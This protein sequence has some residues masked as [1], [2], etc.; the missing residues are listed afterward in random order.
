MQPPRLRV[1]LLVGAVAHRDRQRRAAPDLV[2]RPRRG[3]AEVEAGAPGGGDGARMDPL[4][5]VGAG[6]RPPGRPWSRSTDRQR[7]GTAPSSQCTRT[8]PAPR[9]PVL[10]VR[11][12]RDRS[13]SRWTYRRRPSPLDRLRSI[14]PAASSTSRWWA[15]RFEGTPTSPGAPAATGQ[16]PS[17]GRRSPSG[18]THRAQ[19]GP[20]PAAPTL[21][22]RPRA[23]HVTH[24][25]LRQHLLSELRTTTRSGR[26]AGAQDRRPRVRSQMAR[27]T[28]Q[29]S[30][31]AA[32]RRAWRRQGFRGSSWP[33]RRGR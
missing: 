26:T 6:T 33:A 25:S 10:A 32:R 15:S 23:D 4:G 16:N 8:A 11:A 1:E 30:R 21:D 24:R 3:V 19:R 18:T 28:S 20:Q 12:A 9:W 17:A 7:A 5:R 2:E 13:W 31:R 22:R 27:L 14:S 29:R